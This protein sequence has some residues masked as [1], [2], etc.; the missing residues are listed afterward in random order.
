MTIDIINQLLKAKD[1]KSEIKNTI[2]KLKHQQEET[3]KQLYL[4]KVLNLVQEF[5]DMIESKVLET[6]GIC[7]ADINI[8][9]EEDIGNVIHITPYNKSDSYVDDFVFDENG[10]FVNNQKITNINN[11]F[12]TLDGLNR[13]YVSD[14]LK[15]NKVYN[16][17]IKKGCSKVLIEALLCKE[18]SALLEYSEIEHSLSNQN[19]IP[20]KRIKM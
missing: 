9:V 10:E 3:Q 7:T 6:E 13:D 15:N 4:F 19:Q 16:I 17:K 12:S 1:D 11:L 20:N 2:E 5:E 18:L 14:G 8:S